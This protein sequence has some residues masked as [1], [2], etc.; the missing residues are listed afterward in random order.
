MN[1]VIENPQ[2]MLP[3]PAWPGTGPFGVVEPPDPS[4]RY[5]IDPVAFFVALIGGPILFTIATCWL[6]FI[7]LGA[8]IFGGLPYLLIGTPV[9]LVHLSRNPARPRDIAGVALAVCTVLCLIAL[10]LAA[11]SGVEG[12]ALFVLFVFVCAAIFA[13]SWG[14]CFAVLYRRMAR[15]FFTRPL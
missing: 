13:P 6:L 1:D 5:L 14:A 8:L 3:K 9:L 11:L 12:A 2:H 4:R 10:A 7:P 15:D